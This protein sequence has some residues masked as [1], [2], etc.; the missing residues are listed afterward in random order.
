[1][2]SSVFFIAWKF[3]M[4]LPKYSAVFRNEWS[5]NLGKQIIL[6]V[7]YIFFFSLQESCYALWFSM[8]SGFALKRSKCSGQITLTYHIVSRTPQTKQAKSWQCLKTSL[9]HSLP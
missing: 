8:A 4:N 3:A 5:H 6:L 9:R 7:N 2:R 1:M